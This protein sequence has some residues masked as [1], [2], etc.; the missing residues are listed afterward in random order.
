MLYAMIDF[1]K[2]S[3]MH[4]GS[5]AALLNLDLHIEKGEFVS[6][7][8]A[9]GAGKTTLLRLIYREEKATSGTVSVNGKNLNNMSTKEV[10]LLRRKIG[11]V[12]QDFGL[13][14]Q[15]NVYDNVAFALRVVEV[16][17]KEIGRRVPKVL[18]LVGLLHRQKAY[19]HQLSGGEQ[20]RVAL[21]RALVANPL[22]LVADEPTGNLDPDNAQVVLK[23]LQDI[24]L[25]GTTVVM[26]THAQPL[27]DQLQRRVVTL[28]KGQ[29]VK[30]VQKGRYSLEA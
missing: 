7:V 12:F 11:V 25:R 24:N 15:R 16:S 1:F 6:V 14:P 5:S 20:Q 2:V 9:S 10:A 13:L 29:I 3:K 26:A 17:T 23:L 18:D 21:A 22:V 4:Q 28:E 19:P 27:V 8:G 30:D